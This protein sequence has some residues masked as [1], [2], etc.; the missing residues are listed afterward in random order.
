MRKQSA[1][2]GEAAH[3]G[4]VDGHEGDVEHVGAAERVPGVEDA[5]VAGGDEA[6]GGEQFG[7]AGEAAA[8][9]VSIEA[10]LQEHVGERVCDDRDAGG[11]HRREEAGCVEIVHRVH[12]GQVRAG[13][14]ALEAEAL[15]FVGELFDVPRGRVVV[16]VAV[17]VGH[18]AAFGGDGQE[19]G[20]GLAAERH[21]GF[22]MRGAA[23]DVDAFVEGAAEVVGGFGS[24]EIAHLRK[25]D[26][27]EVEVGGDDPLDVEQ[28][29]DGGEGRVG[30]VDVAAD[31]EQ[32][33]GDCE[34]AELEGAALVVVGGDG[35]ADRIP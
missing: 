5:V 31:G 8:F 22:E 17:Q 35:R 6:A 21:G 3:V 11:R 19:R 27:L 1:I 25:G 7:D 9:R 15:G 33:L 23:D 2:A 4:G 13:D 28:H 10:A 18:Q 12:R 24:G 32:A 16:L 26:E 20:D 29:V 34:I 30:D 14:A